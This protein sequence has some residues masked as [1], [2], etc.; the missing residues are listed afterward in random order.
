MGFKG[1]FWQIIWVF[2]VLINSYSL[3]RYRDCG[4]IRRNDGHKQKFKNRYLISFF[5][6]ALLL[7][8][9]N[10]RE[11]IVKDIR[12]LTMPAINKM[13]AVVIKILN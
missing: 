5:L 6:M 12:F 10:G 8:N 2:F 11:K 9:D 13:R 3:G 1:G 7:A 4:V